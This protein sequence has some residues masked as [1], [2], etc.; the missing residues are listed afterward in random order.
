MPNDIL[1]STQFDIMYINRAVLASLLRRPLKCGRLIVLPVG[2]TARA[3]KNSVP[4]TTHSFS[5][6]P[7]DFSMLLIFSL[8]NVKGGHKLE[9]TH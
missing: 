2:N 5:P 9:L 6:H 1:R 8:K 3:V 4:M 7:V